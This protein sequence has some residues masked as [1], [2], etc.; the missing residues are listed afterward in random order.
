MPRNNKSNAVAEAAVRTGIKYFQQLPP[1]WRIIVLVLVVVVGIGYFI[2]ERS[3]APVSATAAI[4]ALNADG[5]GNYLFCWWNVENLFDDKNDKRRPVDEEYDDPFAEDGHLRQLKL[6][7]IAGELLKLN[8][9][10]GPDIIACCE[11][12]SVRAAELLRGTLNSKITDPKLKYTNIAMKDLDAGRHIA[13]C[14]ITRLPV[15]FARTRLRGTSTR[16][17]E[18]QLRVNGYDLCLVAS[19]WTSQ[20][21]QKGDTVNTAT[22]RGKYASIIYDILM[23]HVK[24]NRNTDFLVCGDFN[25]TPDSETVIKV[26]GAISD[27]AK[28]TPQVQPPYLLN[29]LGGKP[30]DKFGTIS[31]NGKPLIYDQICVSAGMLDNTGWGCKPDSVKVV[32]EALIRPGSTRRQPWRFGNP[33]PE[34]KDSERG[35]S[36]HFPVTVELTVQPSKIGKEQ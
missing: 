9:G 18:T 3:L 23:E 13:T 22:G 15:D 5:S 10:K 4:P 29:L 11:M 14:V 17:L 30:A 1:T 25:D 12:E 19:H 32:T 24:S 16:I 7:H 26:L 34:V 36:D 2:V 8:A 20:I 6:D 28:V 33:K 35:F 31:Y 27:P 21:T